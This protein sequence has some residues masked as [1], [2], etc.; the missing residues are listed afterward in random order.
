MPLTR[1]SFISNVAK[2]GGYAAAFSAM[3]A[4]CLLAEVPPSRLG[5]LP[6]D[7]ARLSHL[8]RVETAKC[9]LISKAYW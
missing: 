1:R 6:Q 3:R 5:S 8:G 9:F 2:A 4:L 7:L